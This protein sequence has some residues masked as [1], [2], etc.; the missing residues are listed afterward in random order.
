MK[1]RTIAIVVAVAGIVAFLVSGFHNE[2][3]GFP[4]AVSDGAWLVF[5]LS[6]L[7]EIGLGI[8]ALV[9]RTRRDKAATRP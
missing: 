4:S 5:M 2:F 1:I 3:S 9:R 8:T 6:V 7:V